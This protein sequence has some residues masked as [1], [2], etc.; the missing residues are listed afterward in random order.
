M[1]KIC[2]YPLEVQHSFAAAWTQPFATLIISVVVINQLIGP[3]QGLR[4]WSVERCA[5]DLAESGL[6]DGC[7][8]QVCCRFGLQKMLATE[9]RDQHEA[10]S[11]HLES[12]IIMHLY[13]K[14]ALKSTPDELNWIDKS[15]SNFLQVSEQIFFLSSSKPHLSASA[16]G[17][18]NGIH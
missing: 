5:D 7:D 10:C 6:R 17:S 1:K 2:P 15:Y 4:M 18:G 8:S 16:V 12:E 11:V 14:W 3:A 13:N 9:Q